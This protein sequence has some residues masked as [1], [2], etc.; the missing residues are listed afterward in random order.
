MDGSFALSSVLYR[1]SSSF[2]QQ[3]VEKIAIMPFPHTVFSLC[4]IAR[5]M[6]P[7]P[8]ADP[9]GFQVLA[10]PPGGAPAPSHDMMDRHYAQAVGS[11][12]GVSI[13]RSNC[14]C[15]SY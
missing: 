12:A 10:Y 8:A 15:L 9:S 11:Q 14:A 1:Y 7:L 6:D 2:V 3:K 5:E 13:D 4:V